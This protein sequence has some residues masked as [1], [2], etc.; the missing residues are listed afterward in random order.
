MLPPPEVSDG[1]DGRPVFVSD[2]GMAAA[3]NLAA[4]DAMPGAP[5][6]VTAV[7]LR[8]SKFAET[9]VLSKAGRWKD[10]PTKAGWTY[11]VL[12]FDAEQSP[13]GRKEVW[14]ATRNPK[15]RQRELRKVDLAVAKVK[16]RL[17]KDDRL[18]DHGHHGCKLLTDRKLKRFVRPGARGKRLFV[19]QERVRLERRRAGVRLIRSTL[20]DLPAE[21]SLHA[22]EQ[23]LEAENDFR[24]LK[25]PIFF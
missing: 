2:S 4:I 19:N 14:I 23:L 16:E 5:D 20:V 22:Y 15:R 21:A 1:S 24:Q 10:H 8:N 9:Q 7:P 13:S 3:K 18:P 12:T 11:R 6:R 25:G 17:A